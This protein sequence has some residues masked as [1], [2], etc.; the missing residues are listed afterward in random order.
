MIGL[1]K[2][3]RNAQITCEI[4]EDLAEKIKKIRKER[5][6]RIGWIVK[7]AVKRYLDGEIK[8]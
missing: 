7:E 3:E 2:E 5:G 1:N 4:D 8:I 6:K